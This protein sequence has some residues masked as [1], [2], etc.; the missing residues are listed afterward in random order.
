MQGQYGFLQQD[1]RF[2]QQQQASNQRQ[3]NANQLQPQQTGYVQPQQTGYVQPQQTGYVQPQQTGFIQSQQTGFA[4][5]QQM[6]YVQPQRTGYMQPQMTGFASGGMMRPQPT[7]YGMQT[8]QTGFAGSSGLPPMPALPSQ[9]QGQQLGLPNSLPAV[10]SR[11]SSGLSPMGSL[12]AQPTGYGMGFSG[13]LP[14]LGASSQPFLNTFMPAPGVSQ[15]SMFGASN[16][17]PSQ[18]QFAQQP[19][20]F[21]GMSLQQT[22]QQQ[23]QQQIGQSQVKVPW[24]LSTEEK[25]SYDQIFRAWDQAGT[26]FIEG[27]M[28]TEVFAQSGLGREDLMQIWGL[29]DVENRGKLNMAEF[30]VA[31]GLIYRRL[32]GNPIPPTLPAEM[33]PPSARDL[34]NSVDFLKDLLKKD[35][36][37]S[38]GESYAQHTLGPVRSLHSNKSSPD[39]RKDATMYKHD[40]YDGS[41]TYKS[42][43]RHIDRRDVRHA[44]NE[45]TGLDDLKREL[46]RTDSIIESSRRENED[47]EGLDHELEDLKYR[48][49]RLQ[50]DIEHNAR[51]GRRSEAKDD[52]R[53]QL[54]RELLRLRHDDLPDLER[55][56]ESRDRERRREANRYAQERDSRNNRSRFEDQGRDRDEYHRRDSAGDRGYLKGSYDRD[57]P[58]RTSERAPRDLPSRNSY[59]EAPSRSS[60]REERSQHDDFDHNSARH[61]SSAPTV[62]KPP[63]PTTT[64]KTMTPEEKKAFIQAEAQRRIQERLRSLGIGGTVSTPAVDPDVNSRL[65]QERQEAAIQASKADVEAEAR[66]KQRQIRL[67][68]ERLGRIQAEEE[69]NSKTAEAIQVKKDTVSIPSSTTAASSNATAVSEEEEALKRREEALAKEKA[70]R[71]ARIKQLE[72]EEEE[73][74]RLEEEFKRKKA[75]FASQEGVSS[76]IGKKAPPPPP[77]PRS[78]AAPPPAPKSRSSQPIIPSVSITE[79]SWE[80]PEV[81]SSSSRE[82]PASKPAS[83]SSSPIASQTPSAPPPPAPPAP[84]APQ[85]SQ[86]PPASAS[87]NPFHRFNPAATDKPVSTPAAS[88]PNTS[89]TNPFFK[90][91][92][93]SQTIST[94]TTPAVQSYRP[95]PRPKDSDDEWDATEEKGDDDSDDEG[96]TTA[97]KA[98]QGLAEALFGGGPSRPQSAAGNITAAPPSA[99]APPAPPIAPAAPRAPGLVVQPSG[100]I[101]RGMLLGE[102]QGGKRLRKAQTNDRSASSLAG[103]V[104][105]GIDPPLPQNDA[106][107]PES[108]KDNRL[109]VDW[110]GGMAADGMHAGAIP[111]PSHLPSLESH[112][113][114]PNAEM[115]ASAV[116]NDNPSED[117]TRDFNMD[118]GLCILMK[119][120]GRM[121]SLFEENLVIRAHPPKTDGDWWYGTVERTGQSGTFPRAYVDELKVSWGEALY[122][123]SASSADEVSLVENTQVPVVDDL[124]DPD[125]LKIED[126]GRIGLAPRAYIEIGVSTSAARQLI[127]VSDHTKTSFEASHT[128]CAVDPPSQSHDNHL[129]S[130]SGPILSTPRP[131]PVRLLNDRQSMTP[132]NLSSM[133]PSTSTSDSLSDEESEPEQDNDELARRNEIERYRILAAAGLVRKPTR[134]QPSPPVRSRRRSSGCGSPPQPTSSSTPPTLRIDSSSADEANDGGIGQQLGSEQ[135]MEDALTR[136]LR[137]QRELPPLPAPVQDSLPMSRQFLTAQASRPISMTMSSTK[138]YQSPHHPGGT[139]GFR[140]WMSDLSKSVVGGGSSHSAS[141]SRRRAVSISSPMSPSPDQPPLS[142]DTTA[143]FGSSWSSLM[144]IETLSTYPDRERNRQE[145]IFELIKTEA[146]FV[147]NCQLLTEVFHRQ[148]APILGFRAS[149]VIFANIEEIMLFGVTFLSALEERQTEDKLL[150]RSIGDI[151]SNH[152]QGLDLYRPYC[153]NQAN[154]ARVLNDLKTRYPEIRDQLNRTKVK[155]LELEHYLL[156][157]MQRLTRYPLLIKQI[158][159]YTDPQAT[160]HGLL[161]SALQKAETVLTATNEAIRDQENEL[162]LASLS[163]NLSIPGCDARLNLTNPSRFV[164]RR[165]LIRDGPV[166]KPRSRKIFHAYLCN[167]FFLLTILPVVTPNPIETPQVMYR[168]PMPLEECQLEAGKDDTS[169]ILIHRSERLTLRFPGGPKVCASW[170]DDF[171]LAR[172]IVYQALTARRDKRASIPNQLCHMPTNDPSPNQEVKNGETHIHPRYQQRY[173]SV[174]Q[175]GLPSASNGGSPRPIEGA[176]KLGNKISTGPVIVED[177]I[178]ESFKRYQL[179]EQPPSLPMVPKTGGCI[180]SVSAFFDIQLNTFY[181]PML[182]RLF[183]LEGNAGF[184]FRLGIGRHKVEACVETLECGSAFLDGLESLSN[185]DKREIAEVGS[186]GLVGLE[187]LGIGVESGITGD[188]MTMGVG[189][190]SLAVG[191]VELARPLG[192]EE[193]EGDS[194]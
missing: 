160:D 132:S 26:G 39:L 83:H 22:F 178:V 165:R 29:A 156:E 81:P 191:N 31:M 123:Y 62:A 152:V 103:K 27:K 25:K 138:S 131:S 146:A 70:A 59:R 78:R 147:Q 182:L 24:K 13:Q 102:I 51:S 93:T 129:D 84:P 58:S 101:D 150:V 49:R 128:V 60:M 133:K 143:S 148:L 32:N 155:G 136:Y 77:M 38:T 17:Q 126:Q 37:R 79:D 68:E 48:I 179:D 5:P 181:S 4:P 112:T 169:L 116:G 100:P 157:P 105:G 149:M 158:I 21:N 134:P 145:A 63:P 36:A 185:P 1:P 135:K 40:E 52:E 176:D 95:P 18:M 55:R 125:W 121:I 9:Y 139:L 106:R 188:S 108:N 192:G 44:G 144:D 72:E 14:A 35:N 42:R 173:H 122:S 186:R 104:L 82:A 2:L 92:S 172:R 119:L 98:R 180:L 6:G 113:E 137:L 189:T 54:E 184:N 73:S 30:H 166:S 91:A 20:Q 10:N 87:T 88:T 7:G 47:D 34:D 61:D 46:D 177:Q 114:E 162:Y 76:P 167:D 85:V 23:N 164:G 33:V 118:N 89:G 187:C 141:T 154:A 94:S 120:N 15:P 175:S 117:V 71:I 107:A 16:F 161:R 11:F 127:P 64:T 193:C 53:R 109:S 171:S 86:L 194:D 174:Y 140:A 65:E 41:G 67:E 56:I 153:T 163:E 69:L 183:E 130:P 50:D 96:A 115:A 3:G 168:A 110:F 45:K 19:N 99:M 75:M 159:K 111:S 74:R 151:I 28:S 97:R 170:K 142:S 190:S 80:A 12:A 43:S 8:Q 124:S 66:E 90:P 57:T